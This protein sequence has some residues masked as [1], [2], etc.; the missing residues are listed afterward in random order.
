MGASTSIFGAAFGLQSTHEWKKSC[1]TV[2]SLNW[3]PECT[4]QKPIGGLLNVNLGFR[5]GIV[6]VEAFGLIAGDYSSGKLDGQPPLVPLPNYATNMQIGRIGGAI[7]GGV[8]VMN[9]G[10]VRLSGGAGAGVVFRHVYTN[11]SSLDGS[12]EGYQSPIIKL[13]VTLTLAKFLNLGVMGWVE[14]SKT[15]QITP[16]LDAAANL[17]GGSGGFELELDLIA[18]GFGEVTVF[19]GPQYFIGP[20]VGFHFG[21]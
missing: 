20:Y 12:S 16:Q 19:K 21:K 3:D 17:V 8:R 1:P 14:F 2:A 5:F 10:A 9:T 6:G 11:V 15:I 4:T 18:E 13:D 7:G